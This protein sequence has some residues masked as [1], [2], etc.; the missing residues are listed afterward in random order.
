MLVIHG[1]QYQCVVSMSAWSLATKVYI[2]NNTGSSPG[3]HTNL[4]S[5]STMVLLN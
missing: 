2:P 3:L 1:R 4:Q 5:S